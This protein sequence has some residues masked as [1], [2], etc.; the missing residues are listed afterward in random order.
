[1]TLE[2]LSMKIKCL[3]PLLCFIWV[4]GFCSEPIDRV[5]A[6]VNDHVVTE[7][8]LNTQLH[9]MGPQWENLEPEKKEA[10]KKQTLEGMINKELQLQ[11]AKNI[12]IT[13]TSDQVQEAIAHIAEQNKMSVPDMEKKI[14]EQ[15]LSAEQYY[16]EIKDEL[17]VH[18]LQEQE[19]AS[20]IQ[21]N[22]QQVNDFIRQNGHL[23]A[24]NKQFHVRDVL[25]PVDNP[26][27]DKVNTLKPVL[28][29]IRTALL[30]KQ[31]IPNDLSAQ[32]NDL[33]TRKLNEF[34]DI[35]QPALTGL[36]AGEVSTPVLAPN[37]V[38]LLQVTE[39][40]GDEKHYS[41]ETHVRHILIKEDAL[42]TGPIVQA[43]LVQL[44][45]QIANGGDFAEIARLNSQDPVSAANGGDLGWVKTAAGLLDPKFEAEMVNLPI[46]D[47]SPV[48]K[49]RFGYHLIQVLGRRKV[50]DT[51]EM[52]AMQ[53]REMIFQQKFNEKLQAYLKQ[54]RAQAYVKINDA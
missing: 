44:R 10:F 15:G 22:D 30:N 37:G 46:G 49:S 21:I 3:I 6:V 51:K 50:E 45:G 47:L 17:I 1:M 35:F 52:L 53:A 16:Q 13:V 19:I 34:P 38:H 36:T 8:Q 4:S 29:K 40:Q 42:N 7:S 11:M 41:V 23:L 20:Q 5:V 24:Q 39:A 27:P 54:L 48:I 2:N 26:T 43:R 12:N 18:R 9:L 32:L 25:V 14:G 33:G 31:D 28:D